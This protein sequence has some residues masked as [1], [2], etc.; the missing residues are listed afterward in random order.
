MELTKID[1]NIQK[2]L[3]EIINRSTLVAP[4]LEEV[5]AQTGRAYLVGGAVRDLLLGLP[6]KDIDIE[7]HD[8]SSEKLEKLLEKFG[9]VSLVGK[10]F[11]VF[12]LH[13]L[14]VDWSL[15]RADSAG[16]KPTVAFD[17]Q[18]DIITALRRR[19][20]TMNAMAID[21][22]TNELIDP[23][24][25]A[26]DLKKNLLRTPDEHFFVEDPLRFYRVMQFVARFCMQ[27]DEQLNNLCARM[28]LKGVS[29][30]RISQ[31][32][33]K[34][35]LKAEQPSLG[36]RWLRSIDRLHELLPE[37]GA[38]VGV[39]Q[40]PAWHPEGDV[41]EHTMQTIDAAA[42][43][44][45]ENTHQKLIMLLAALCHDLGKVKTTELVEGTWKSIGHAKESVAL[46]KRLLG[47]ITIN[48]QLIAP[49]CTLVHYHMH[50]LMFIA[51]KAKPAA[52]KRLAHKL[53]PT[54]TLAQLATLAMADSLGRNPV[55]GKPLAKADSEILQ[56]VERAEAAM[57]LVQKEQPLLQGR[58]LIGLVPPGPQ[59]GNVL[60]RAY[61]LQLKEGITS[62]DELLKKLSLIK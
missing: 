60:K 32:F 27:P 62:K 52:Y 24:N 18:M 11:G 10:V 6:I 38:L 26:E 34:M 61:T 42:R 14:D 48:K 19:D 1:E 53:A 56:F 37:I 9:P 25:G 54:C 49:V 50:V 21:L 20:L 17:P 58:D 15:P 13:G 51:D 41:F 57:V 35:L 30:E 22:Q 44:T 45:Y 36:I 3:K 59:M 4:I 16:R 12:R 46:T 7:I 31:E 55:A 29:K 40:N 33:E 23:F 5:Y 47:R 43:F 8:L 2:S 39:Q 28:S